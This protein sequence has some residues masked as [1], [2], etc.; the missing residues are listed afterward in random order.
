MRFWSA[1]VQTAL[2]SSKLQL[3]PVSDASTKLQSASRAAFHVL[4][5][6]CPLLGA[7]RT[8]GCS[9]VGT[10]RSNAIVHV[11]HAKRVRGHLKA[12]RVR[13]GNRPRF[14]RLAMLQRGTRGV[15]RGVSAVGATLNLGR[16]ERA[17]PG[18]VYRNQCSSVEVSARPGC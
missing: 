1:G 14:D 12:Q 9:N 17:G 16:L 10:T 11:L 5:H 15:Q 8:A 7:R 2:R 3:L 4:G 13:I 18:A 6:A